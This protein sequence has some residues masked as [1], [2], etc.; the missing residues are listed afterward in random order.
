MATFPPSEEKFRE[1]TL[2]LGYF[3]DEEW[4]RCK[5]RLI[6]QKDLILEIFERNN[7]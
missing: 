1:I 3:T 5:S 6:Q 7:L 2:H 4:E